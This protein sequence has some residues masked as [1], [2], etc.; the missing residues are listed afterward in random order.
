MVPWMAYNY[1]N[2]TQSL[3]SSIEDFGSQLAA[4]LISHNP[5]TVAQLQSRYNSKSSIVPFT[6]PAKKIRILLVP[7]HEPNYGGAEYG[8]LK[9]RNLTVELAQDLQQFLAKNDRYEV[10]VTRDTQA[11]SP[12]FTNYFSAD[13]N[14]IIA[15]QQ[16]HKDEI[17]NLE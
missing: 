11:W 14:D 16:A 6:P 15:W 12:T 13:W 10:F 2:E 17:I 1:P 8:S 4:V 5:K 9:E 7:G 3:F